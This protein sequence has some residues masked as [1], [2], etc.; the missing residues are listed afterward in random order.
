MEVLFQG[1]KRLF[2]QRS[3]H[4]DGIYTKTKFLRKKWLHNHLMNNIGL[5][6]DQKIFDKSWNGLNKYLFNV[7]E[8]PEERNDLF[9]SEPEIVEQFRR[10][11]REHLGSFTERDSPEKSSR[12]HPSNFGNVWS[13]GWCG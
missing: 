1:S 8:D 10:R 3:S 6:A 13:P 5:T 12:G 2:G 9:H 7:E 11:V 4:H